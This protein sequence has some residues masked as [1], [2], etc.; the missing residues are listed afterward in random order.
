MLAYGGDLIDSRFFDGRIGRQGVYSGGGLAS[1][2][3]TPEALRNYLKFEIARGAR[4][5]K[6]A[7]IKPNQTRATVRHDRLPDRNLVLRIRGLARHALVDLLHE[8][9]FRSESTACRNMRE[10][11]CSQPVAKASDQSRWPE[12]LQHALRARLRE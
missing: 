7:G 4:V 5:V 6:A 12:H 9:S 11:A 3:A 2:R 10:R 1:V 8:K